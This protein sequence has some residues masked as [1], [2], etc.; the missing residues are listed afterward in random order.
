MPVW[1]AVLAACPSERLDEGRL[2]KSMKMILR[3]FMLYFL[4]STYRIWRRSGNRERILQRERSAQAAWRGASVPQRPDRR[5]MGAEA[6][7]SRRLLL[8]RPA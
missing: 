8:P 3:E 7:H 1:Y 6:L 2:L 4:I 5:L